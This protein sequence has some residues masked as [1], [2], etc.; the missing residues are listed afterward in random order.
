LFTIRRYGPGPKDP[1]G[2]PTR[3][4]VRE[5]VVDCI[6]RQTGSVEGEAF[7]VDE[8]R[9]ALPLNTDHRPADEIICKGRVYTLQG[10]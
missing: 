2:K 3:V 8:F 9:A 6:I 1:L 10:S 5:E 4:V 7:V